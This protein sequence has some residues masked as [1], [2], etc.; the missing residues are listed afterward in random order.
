MG[1]SASLSMSSSKASGDFLCVREQSGIHAD[2]GGFQLNVT[3]NTDLRGGLIASSDTA[4]ANGR[5]SGR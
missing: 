3:G 1:S 4:I 5:D 2:D